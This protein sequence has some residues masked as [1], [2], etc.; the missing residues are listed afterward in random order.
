MSLIVSGG[1]AAVGRLA[2]VS[3][4][5]A[6]V[7]GDWGEPAPTMRAVRLASLERIEPADVESGTQ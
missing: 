3:T 7:V 2:H 5:S 4:R 1:F 6:F